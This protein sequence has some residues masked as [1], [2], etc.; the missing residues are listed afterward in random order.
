ML[1]DKF[2]R[3]NLRGGGLFFVTLIGNEKFRCARELF[4]L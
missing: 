4:C 1:A 2:C 3:N